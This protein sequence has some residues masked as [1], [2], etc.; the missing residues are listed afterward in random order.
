M[1]IEF[2]DSALSKRRQSRISLIALLAV[3]FFS[4]LLSK[5]L[6]ESPL[7]IATLI[8]GAPVLFFV[9]SEKSRFTGLL[10]IFGLAPF[11]S[12]V[13]AFTGIR[14]A[15]ITLDLALFVLV[16]AASLTYWVFGRRPFQALDILIIAFLSLAFLQIFNPNVPSIFVG[17]EG[18]RLLAFQ[19]L[20]YFAAILLVKTKEDIKAVMTVILIA[21]TI[22]ALYAI[23]Q[24]F[25]PSWWDL[26]II[27]MTTA[28]AATFTSSGRMRAFSTLPS[29]AHLSMLLVLSVLISLF[30]I[31]Q[32]IK[33]RICIFFLFPLLFSFSL[34][35][36]RAGWVALGVGLATSVFFAIRQRRRK[37]AFMVVLA[38]VIAVM[39]IFRLLPSLREMSEIYT[40]LTSLRHVTQEYHWQ[41]RVISWRRY[42]LPSVILNPLGY[43][44]G[45]AADNL[46]HAFTG[47]RTFTSHS[48]YL[49]IALELGVLGLLLFIAISWKI[50]RIGLSTFSKIQDDFLRGTTVTILSFFAA[51]LVGGIVGPFTDTYPTNLYL[52]FLLGLLTKIKNI[53]AKHANL[54]TT[55]LPQNGS[56]YD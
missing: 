56:T 10:L 15:P 29:A 4:I 22:V 9:I 5:L 41:G 48:T 43:G 51:F 53:D 52:W 36:V 24:Y 55:T 54:A 42:L 46:H 14:Y 7:L 26:R 47:Y 35:I 17:L 44:T 18:F 37:T 39:L 49:K 11:V 28:S 33:R 45:A 12:I 34:T 16:A 21:S 30:F 19:C 27:D 2:L 32:G 31:I 13:K 6:T 40:A 50:I 20:G 8:L 25:W 38:S 1:N 3:S 23:K